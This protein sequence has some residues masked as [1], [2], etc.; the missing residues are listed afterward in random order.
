MQFIPGFKNLAFST[1]TLCVN[2][3]QGVANVMHTVV[4]GDDWSFS[5]EDFPARISRVKTSAIPTKD[6]GGG[7]HVKV[8][9][10]LGS[11]SNRAPTRKKFSCRMRLFYDYDHEPSSQFQN[12][13]DQTIGGR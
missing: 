1:S 4:E 8:E 10:L 9:A 13:N 2:M 3:V 7:Y 5:R 11:G 12:L 6:A